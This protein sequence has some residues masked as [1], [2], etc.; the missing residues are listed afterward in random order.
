M[1]RYYVFNSSQLKLDGGAMFGIIPKPLWSKKLAADEQNRI[2]MTMRILFIKTPQRLI[3]IDAG[4]GNHH[5]ESFN[6]RYG[7]SH[8]PQAYGD[9]LQS[10]AAPFKPEDV[11]D[12]IL[13]HLHFD[14]ADGA[15]QGASLATTFPQA[16]LH[17]H[18]QHA[19]YSRAAGARDAGSFHRDII[20]NIIAQYESKGKLQWI[21]ETQ[22]T[23]FNEV[24]EIPLSFKCL[25][26]HTPFQLLLFNEEIVFLT[27]LIPTHAHL[28]LPWVMGYDLH[29]GLSVVEK[30]ATLMLVKERKL[31]CIFNHDAQYLGGHLSWSPEKGWHWKQLVEQTKRFQT[32]DVFNLKISNEDRP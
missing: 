16:T 2:L 30:E 4:A 11:T 1:N 28:N 22:G 24:G 25:H 32:I 31:F 27:D 18:Q 14:H 17:L 7:I 10:E 12:L 21:E 6:L 5:S 26:G 3:A 23:L 20:E 15:L 13:T 19:L 9:L 8:P 29:A